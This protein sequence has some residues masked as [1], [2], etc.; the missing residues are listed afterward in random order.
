MTIE[1]GSGNLLT[2]DV[3]ALVNTVN[4]H[5]VMG[6]G[7]ALQ[8]KKAFPDAFTSYERACKN[9]EIVTGRM[10]VVRRLSSPRYII[11][12]PTKKHWRNPSKLEYI[13]T[14][15]SDLVEQVRALSIESVAIP[16]LGCG[17]GGL[18][19]SEVRPLIEGAF[20]SLPHVRVILYAPAGAPAASEMLDRRSTP[21]MTAA[22]AA[23]LALMGRYRSTGYDYRLSLV[24]IQKLAYF[25][26]TAGE[27]LRLKFEA[28]HYGPYADNLR[29]SLRHMEGH[30]IRGIGDGDNKPEVEVE[31]LPGVGERA[32]EV[33]AQQPASVARLEKVTALIEGFES[34]FG[35][36][37]LGTVHWVMTHGA[38]AT[39]VDDVIKRV[40]TWSARKRSTMKDGHIRAAWSRLTEMGWAALSR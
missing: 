27:P 8:F 29:K 10:H 26:Q 30:L 7:L 19:W 15:L 22:R 13:Q 20:A 23:V 17:Q 32:T 21:A 28:H 25:L 5:G 40:H 31:L 24:E 33:L 2:A 3:D 37:L 35:M 34:P 38:D 1:L 14:G 6:K 16:P 39:D 18:D 36:E 12:F 11:N 9:G 4:T